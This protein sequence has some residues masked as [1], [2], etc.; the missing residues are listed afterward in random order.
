MLMRGDGI[1]NEELRHIMF[2]NAKI[3]C[4]H[5]YVSMVDTEGIK[6]HFICLQ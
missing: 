5:D 3:P 1:L 4:T 6:K 2:H